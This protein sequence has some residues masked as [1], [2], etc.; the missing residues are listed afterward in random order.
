MHLKSSQ[1]ETPYKHHTL[2]LMSEQTF[3][4]WLRQNWQSLP[5]G[6]KRKI[7][8]VVWHWSDIRSSFSLSHAHCRIPSFATCSHYMSSQQVL[9]R[10]SKHHTCCLDSSTYHHKA[11]FL[12]ESILHRIQALIWSLTW[13][14][15][16]KLF[17]WPLNLGNL[18]GTRSSKRSQCQSCNSS[19]ARESWGTRLAPGE[20][21][22]F[23]WRKRPDRGKIDATRTMPS[24]RRPLSIGLYM[25]SLY[26]S[27]TS[28]SCSD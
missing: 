20:L 12:H 19:W 11:I 9:L 21:F 24:P 8:C 3:P 22:S 23:E 2:N 6:R 5:S 10:M 18:I 25:Y 15:E 7:S 4:K 16:L 1:P 17:K 14:M 27:P 26:R 28:S 13:N